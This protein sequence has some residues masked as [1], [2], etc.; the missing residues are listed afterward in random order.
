M[1]DP[2]QNRALRLIVYAW[3]LS[4]LLQHP[5]YVWKQMSPISISGEKSF[6]SIIASS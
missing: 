3:V 4:E 6:H 5:V 1:L 2:I